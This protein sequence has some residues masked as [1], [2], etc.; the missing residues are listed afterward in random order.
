MGQEVSGRAS[1]HPGARTCVFRVSGIIEIPAHDNVVVV[2]NPYLTIAGQ[3]A[4]GEGVVI[5]G[6]ELMISTHDVIIRHLRVRPG[7]EPTGGFSSLGA[8]EAFQ[9]ENVTFVDHCSM[10][11]GSRRYGGRLGRCHEEYYLPMEFDCR[12]SQYAHDQPARQRVRHWSRGNA[13][14]FNPQSDGQLKRTR[15]LCVE[16][17]CTGGQ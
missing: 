2:K 10:T 5:K 4:P 11:W 3:T 15:A 17:R 6:A 1:K 16:R 9:G 13:H 14:V 8:I 7:P 12:R